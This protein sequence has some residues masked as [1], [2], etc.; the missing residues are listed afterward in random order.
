MIPKKKPPF[1]P[2]PSS[3]RYAGGG[4]TAWQ[5]QPDILW[6]LRLLPDCVA[7]TLHWEDALVSDEDLVTEKAVPRMCSTI[8][9]RLCLWSHVKEILCKF[10]LYPTKYAGYLYKGLVDFQCQ[11]R[12]PSHISP[13]TL[14]N[15]YNFHGSLVLISSLCSL[16]S[17][18]SPKV[19]HLWLVLGTF[20]VCIWRYQ[21][22]P[23]TLMES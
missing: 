18:L 17:H 23:H 5:S 13:M 22:W 12:R 8:W 10:E 2:R 7:H 9:G 14:G 11:P 3:S 19:I 6:M 20:S 15:L 1:I 16:P 4:E 21:Q